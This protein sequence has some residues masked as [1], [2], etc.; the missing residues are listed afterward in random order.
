MKGLATNSPL[1]IGGTDPP[2]NAILKTPLPT[3]STVNGGSQDGEMQKPR[4]SSVL[5]M[6]GLD[7]TPN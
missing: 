7:V 5:V 6:L 1:A 4:G 2:V 3:P